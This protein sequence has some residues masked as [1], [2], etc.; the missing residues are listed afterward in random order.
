M[1]VKNEASMQQQGTISKLISCTVK[2]INTFEY[3]CTDQLNQNT[4]EFTLKLILQLYLIQL[5][6]NMANL[7]LYRVH[8]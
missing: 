2:E 7:S 5:F 3:D 4:D 8:D 6:C 1:V